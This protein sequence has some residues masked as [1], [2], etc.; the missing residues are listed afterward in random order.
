MTPPAAAGDATADAIG[1][2]VGAAVGDVGT[3]AGP[4]TPRPWLRFGVGATRLKGHE[5]RGVWE[6]Q[7]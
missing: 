4:R 3:G 5:Q 6:V 2:T 7:A 1:N